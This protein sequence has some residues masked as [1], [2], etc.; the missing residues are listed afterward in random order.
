MSA[1]VAAQLFYRLL[2]STFD[3]MLAISQQANIEL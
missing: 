2:H 1:R 3:I